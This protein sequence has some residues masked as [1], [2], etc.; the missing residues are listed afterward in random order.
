MDKINL[1]I[2]L[3]QRINVEVELDELIDGINDCEMKNRWN[4]ISR[5]LNGV[6]LNLTDLTEEHKEVVKKYLKNKLDLFE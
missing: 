6:Q 5:M 4:Y 3:N 1:E 2:K